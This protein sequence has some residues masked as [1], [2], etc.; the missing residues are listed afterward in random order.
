MTRISTILRANIHEILDRAEDPEKA[1][2]QMVRDMSEAVRD[3][4]KQVAEAIAQGKVA[5]GNLHQADEL[6]AQW[7]RKAEVAVARGSS[8]L[9]RECLLRK[10]DFDQQAHL[11]HQ[12]LD[13]LQPSI[14][15]MKAQLRLLEFKQR[16]LES[17]RAQ[18]LSRYKVAKAHEK[19]RKA[20]TSMSIY[21]PSSDLARM[22]E[23]IRLVEAREQ[24]A[25]E[26]A[27]SSTDARLAML[28]FE[29]SDPE[30]EAELL[31]IEAK[32]APALSPGVAETLRALEA[33]IDAGG[34]A[35]GASQPPSRS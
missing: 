22:D 5:E 3:A 7:R 1:L 32:Y 17:N 20:V 11:Y 33:E 34:S 24:A 6:A 27:A 21:D 2:N 31:E 15:Q 29:T 16:E 14:D 28:L 18:L 4:R 35:A 12:Q 9:A 19:V 8:D 30:I 25:G 26:L 10:K 23:R 13:S